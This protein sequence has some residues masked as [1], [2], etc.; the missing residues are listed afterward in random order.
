MIDFGMNLQE[1]GD[2]PRI[3]H[4]GSSQPTDEVMSDGGTVNLESGFR[5][6]VIQQLMRM[7]H[8]IQ[9]D[10]GGYGGYQAILRDRNN[11]YY[12]ASESRKDGQAAGY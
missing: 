9:W 5:T 10:L 7:G 11:V 1:A 2:A 4:V 3:R 6:E 8:K 12:G